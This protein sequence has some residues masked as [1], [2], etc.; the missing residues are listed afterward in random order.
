MMG[1]G[2]KKKKKTPQLAIC[3]P[4]EVKQAQQEAHGH[5]DRHHED[6]ADLE[7]DTGMEIDENHHK[8]RSVQPTEEGKF[9]NDPESDK[10][11]TQKGKGK[12]KKAPLVTG[13]RKAT[14]PK[15]GKSGPAQPAAAH[16][17]MLG[18]AEHEMEPNDSD[19]FESDEEPNGE[20]NQPSSVRNNIKMKRHLT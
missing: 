16:R 1:G 18:M 20:Q 4:Q 10:P 15:Y 9:E 12:G 7:L 6:L 11:K 5:L 13:A 17:E 3:G 14:C 8:M 19:D 2:V